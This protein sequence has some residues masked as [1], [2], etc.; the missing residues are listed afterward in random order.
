MILRLA[1]VALLASNVVAPAR[2]DGARIPPAH[3]AVPA[4]PARAAAP[5]TAA[6]PAPPAF[7]WVA[8]SPVRPATPAAPAP[9]ARASEAARP[10]PE[11]LARQARRRAPEPPDAGE[12]IHTDTT[13]SVPARSRLELNNF[14]GAIIVSAWDRNALRV[15]ADHVRGT[16]IGLEVGPATVVVRS[17]T[18]MVVG[19]PDGRRMRIERPDFPRQV[20]YRLTVPRWMSLR[21]SGV[22]SE[23]LIE[24]VQGDVS[25]E[26]VTGPV[27]VRGGRGN[28]R[29]SAIN[30]GVEVAGTRGSVEASSMSEDVTVRDVEGPVRVETVNGNVELMEILSDDVEAN[31]V[32]GDLRYVGTIRPGGSYRFSTHSGNIVVALPEHPDVAASVNTYSGEFHSSFPLQ[33]GAM[34]PRQEFDFTLG[35]GRAELD[36][37]SFSGSIR[38]VRAREVLESLRH[39]ASQGR[40]KR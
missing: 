31:T 28:V 1:L 23:M 29:V 40:G 13:V 26:A 33:I 9:P 19:L 7:A 15:Q 18:R 4:P 8:A 12:T 34:K 30:G 25:A 39:R 20:D 14:G 35:D 27:A 10:A 3:P 22:R 5:A 37:E 36:L 17:M 6:N 11:A 21:L 38:L 32:S 16:H 24:G 2:C